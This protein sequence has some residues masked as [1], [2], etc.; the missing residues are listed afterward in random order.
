MET[1]STITIGA[2]RF[3]EYK[4]KSTHM[5]HMPGM[6]RSLMAMRDTD[7][8]RAAELFF[9]M[10]PSRGKVWSALVDGRWHVAD[11]NATVVVSVPVE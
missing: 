7:K 4:L 5:I 10:F 6:I 1:G 8:T 9:A 3:V 11:D 2:M